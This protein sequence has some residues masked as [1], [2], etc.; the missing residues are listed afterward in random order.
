[1]SKRLRATLLHIVYSKLRKIAIVFIF[2]RI[3]IVTSSTTLPVSSSLLPRNPPN[4][5]AF[6]PLPAMRLSSRNS[7]N[8]KAFRPIMPYSAPVCEGMHYHKTG[9]PWHTNNI[10]IFPIFPLF[11]GFSR[12]STFLYFHL[13]LAYLCISWH[14]FVSNSGKFFG[15]FQVC[16]KGFSAVGKRQVRNW[17]LR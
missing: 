13:I 9:V 7:S 14:I 12:L 2:F 10:L 16:T 4:T 1:M 11:S 6:I 3:F 8:S 15:K 17:G 5:F